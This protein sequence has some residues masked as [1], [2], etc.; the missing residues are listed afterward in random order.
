MLH[1][2]LQVSKASIIIAIL[3]AKYKQYFIV[4]VVELISE[5][6]HAFYLFISLMLQ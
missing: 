4:T 5:D 2:L 6:L 3:I 1:N